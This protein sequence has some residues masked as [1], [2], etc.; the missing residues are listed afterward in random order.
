MKAISSAAY[1]YSDV[2][3][4]SGLQRR[5]SFLDHF[6]SYCIPLIFASH[7]ESSCS[8]VMGYY[9]AHLLQGIFQLTADS[10][11]TM[12]PSSPFPIIS[13]YPFPNASLKTHS[14]S[15]VGWT[16]LPISLHPPSLCPHSRILNFGMTELGLRS[17]P[18]PLNSVVQVSVIFVVQA[19]PD[20]RIPLQ[21]HQ[22]QS[23]NSWKSVL[24]PQ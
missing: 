19:T 3:P 20:G 16:R 1:S 11:E 8:W 18:D 21:N 13:S 6:C 23:N 10:N 15:L 2:R 7:A 17:W 14:R 12:R 5:P 4:L 24:P 9:S 22:C